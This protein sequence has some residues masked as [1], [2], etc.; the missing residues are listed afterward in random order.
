MRELIRSNDPVLMSFA[1]SILRDAGIETVVLDQN[2]S[3]MEGSIGVFQPRMMV[4]TDSW[5]EAVRVLEGADL[6]RWVNRD[7]KN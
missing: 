4:A 2:I 1:R 6:G 5:N 7:G 3:V